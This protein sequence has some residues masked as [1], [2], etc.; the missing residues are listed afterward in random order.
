MNYYPTYPYAV[1]GNMLLYPL[2]PAQ[3]ALSTLPGQLRPMPHDVPEYFLNE[4]DFDPYDESDD[5]ADN[6]EVIDALNFEENVVYKKAY[7]HEKSTHP[8]TEYYENTKIEYN[9]AKTV[10][11]QIENYTHEKAIRFIAKTFV[12]EIRDPILPE[13]PSVPRTEMKAVFQFCLVDNIHAIYRVIS[14]KNNKYILLACH[15]NIH[16]FSRGD[17][18]FLE[19]NN[20]TKTNGSELSCIGHLA[21]GDLV[22]VTGLKKLRKEIDKTPNVYEVTTETSCIW[23]VTE[24]TLLKRQKFRNVPFSFL[25]NGTAVALKWGQVLTV[26][27][28]EK[29]TNKDNIVFLGSG[30]IPEKVDEFPAGPSPDQLMQLSGLIREITKYSLPTGTI[31]T[32]VYSPYYTQQME[33]GLNAYRTNVPDPDGVVELCALMGATAATAVTSGNF[34]CRSF[35][36]LQ[37]SKQQ[38]V[39]FFSIE[40]TDDPKPFGLWKSSTRV[41]ISSSV[42]DANAIIETAIINQNLVSFSAR[43]TREHTE[44]RFTDEVHIVSQQEMPEGKQLRDGFLEEIPFGSNGKMILTALYGGPSIYVPPLSRLYSFSFPATNPIILNRFQNEYVNRLLQ[45]TPLTLANSPF[46]SGKSMTIATAAYHAVLESRSLKDGTQHLLVTQSNFASVNLVDITKK[47]INKCRVIRYVSEA[48]WLELPDEGRTDLDLPVQMQRVFIDY[49]SGNAQTEQNYLFQMAIYLKEKTVMIVE[50]MEPR[51]QNFFVLNPEARKYDF[52]KLT[53]AFFSVCKPEIII[54]TSESLRG[55]LPVLSR[56]STVQFDEASQIPECA[57]IQVLSTF[58]YACFGLVGDINQLPPYCDYLMTG[59]LKLFGIGSTMERVIRNNLFPQVVLR[60]VYRCHP[61]TTQIL[62]CE[63]YGGRLISGTTVQARSEFMTRR[64]DFWP[65]QNFPIMVIDNKKATDTVGTS[66][67]NQDELVI[68]QKIVCSL[69]SLN[70]NYPINPSDI[71]II[72]YYKAQTDLLCEIFGDL[73]IKCGTIDSFQGTEREIMILCCTNENV[74]TF[75]RLRNRINVAMSRAK[76]TTI[77]IGNVSELERAEH[78]STFVALARSNG[79][80]RLSSAYI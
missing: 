49:V 25:D 23:M 32:H 24:M 22:A 35:R 44:F 80:I 76:Q 57:L 70:S 42:F 62:G 27:N 69:I 7:E 63:F 3:P 14:V 17:L 52:T 47:Y 60:Y 36:M 45:K 67:V 10:H 58:P 6:A 31:F 5:E 1:H 71:G 12:W 55:V 34:D 54:T 56:V 20:R 26:R 73:N 48:S 77:I 53:E 18:R 59:N 28:P 68:V 4:E 64:P 2:P 78:W 30:F 9:F 8:F 46:G 33:I 41:T 29:Y 51:C 50:D 74:N 11:A 39:I 61:V 40:N 38:D 72:S 43:L 65:N 21:L 66:R 37:T 13:R 16:A 19:V 79:C 15:M 75:L